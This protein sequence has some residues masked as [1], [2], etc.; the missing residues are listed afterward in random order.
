M[1]YF[2]AEDIHEQIAAYYHMQI[3]GHARGFYAGG[4]HLLARAD[5]GSL[6]TVNY[7]LN[8]YPPGENDVLTVIT[9]DA[10]RLRP[11]ARVNGA[12][13]RDAAE[14]AYG[15]GI[16]M[17]NALTGDKKG[18]YFYPEML[19]KHPFKEA[20]AAPC[21]WRRLTGRFAHHNAYFFIAVDTDVEPLL[22]WLDTR[23]RFV[24]RAEAKPLTDAETARAN[25][26]AGALKLTAAMRGDLLELAGK[27]KTRNGDL[28]VLNTFRPDHANGK[29][30]AK[31]FYGRL[32]RLLLE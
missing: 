31:D 18:E 20:A 9:A 15:P 27:Y 21:V 29:K 25:E 22:N 5:D 23:S 2:I 19:F 7:M 17:I 26:I 32:R 24:L 1:I 4:G 30:E 14:S 13:A 16:Y 8:K 12:D 28:S 6:E 11:S 10:A 3:T